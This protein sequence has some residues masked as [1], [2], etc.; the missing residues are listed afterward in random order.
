[1]VT[2][3]KGNVSKRARLGISACEGVAEAM[4]VYP[5]HEEI[6]REGC[7]ALKVLAFSRNA[8]KAHLGK[9]AVPVLA[10]VLTV[11]INSEDIVEKVT[12]AI[13]HFAKEDATNRA[14]LAA[15]GVCPLL[16]KVAGTFCL[17]NKHIAEY[18][19]GAIWHICVE[20][21]ANRSTFGKEGCVAVISMMKWHVDC[22]AVALE[23]CGA[24]S[25]LAEGHTGNKTILGKSGGCEAVL[26][27]MSRHPTNTFIAHMGCCA[28]ASMTKANAPNKA[29][30]AELGAGVVLCDT[31]SRHID[32]QTV[33][34]EGS[35]ALHNL[36]SIDDIAMAL[37]DLGACEVIVS[38]IRQHLQNHHVMREAVKSAMRLCA[39]GGAPNAVRLIEAGLIELA[40]AAEEERSELPEDVRVWARKAITL[41]ESF[42]PHMFTAE[43]AE[44]DANAPEV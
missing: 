33:S 2:L 27:A 23:G 20:N 9:V 26:T 34:Q 8:H 30:L 18:V 6:A 38:V 1:V 37:G 5:Q 4:R 22:P 42:A 43:D 28:C 41:C 17:T 10:Q 24:I 16:L 29:K 39:G 25:F 21:P 44:E 32:L 3:A 15:L 19:C 11:H 7:V 40:I 12:L 13:M 14:R 35:L 31:I 36:A